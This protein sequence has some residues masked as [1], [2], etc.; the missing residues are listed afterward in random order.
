MCC[1]PLTISSLPKV[2]PVAPIS[3]YEQ[4]S[5]LRRISSTC[6]TTGYLICSAAPDTN[7]GRLPLPPSLLYL[8]NPSSCTSH[9]LDW[10]RN[11][12]SCQRLPGHL[13]GMF[14]L[15]SVNRRILAV[16]CKRSLE[17]DPLWNRAYRSRGLLLADGIGRQGHRESRFR[18]IIRRDVFNHLIIRQATGDMRIK[19]IYSPKRG[20]VLPMPPRYPP[21]EGSDQARVLLL[22]DVSSRRS[23]PQERRQR[24]RL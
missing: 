23:T 15:V 24:N 16:L 1:V 17:D 20:L 19:D 6:P 9:Q 11:N 13:E 3:N 22:R 14:P 7:V 10:N 5:V 4:C 8:A 12:R 21:E 18:E 2:A